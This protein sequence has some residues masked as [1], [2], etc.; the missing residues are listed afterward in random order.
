MAE[1]RWRVAVIDS[2]IAAGIPVSGARRFVDQ[3][4]VVEA[5][6]VTADVSGH[7]TAVARLLLESGAVELLV[8][9][10]LD[11][12]GRSTPASVAAGIDWAVAT[13]VHLVHL[14]L[15]LAAD[16]PVLAAAVAR[17]VT[18]RV[19][20]V[21]A[22]PARGAQTWPAA[23][24]GVVRATGDARCGPGQISH[25]ASPSADFG[26]CAQFTLPG[27][28]TLRGASIGAARVTASV[29][30]ACAPGIPRGEAIDALQRGASYTGT[31]RRSVA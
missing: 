23:Y 25:L 30:R 3:R 1:G 16:R 28:R 13:G 7:G 8:A 22:V 31:E 20:V 27:G 4:G 19:I 29:V 18:A 21:A 24:P 12:R 5:L 2:G 14:S 11:E 10:V 26:G 9:Q 6:E 15:G 17:A